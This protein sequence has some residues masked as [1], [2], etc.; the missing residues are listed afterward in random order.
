MEL[1]EANKLMGIV[2]ESVQKIIE[3]KE[4]VDAKRMSDSKAHLIYEG[5]EFCYLEMLEMQDKL[6]KFAIGEENE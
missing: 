5:L 6:E 2:N 1:E 4:K 3:V